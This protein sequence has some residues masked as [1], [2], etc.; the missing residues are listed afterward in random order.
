VIL[1]RKESSIETREISPC[2]TSNDY[3]FP[4][5]ALPETLKGCVQ[6]TSL[7][8]RLQLAESKWPD[9]AG[10]LFN[11]TCYLN[12]RPIPRIESQSWSM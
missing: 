6:K 1:K 10:K 9:G 7:D 3:F 5:E 11:Y 4:V 8:W 12:A 2:H